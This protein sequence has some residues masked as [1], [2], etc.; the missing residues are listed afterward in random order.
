VTAEIAILNRSAI[1]LASDSAVTIDTPTGPKIYEG[2]NKIFALVKGRP[3]GVMIYDSAEHLGVPWETIIKAYR[4]SRKD[5]YFPTLEEYAADFLAFVTDSTDLIPIS[6]HTAYLEEVAEQRA[7][8]VVERTSEI[9]HEHLKHGK[10]LTKTQ[11]RQFIGKAVEDERNAWLARSDGQWAAA[12]AITQL[13]KKH[14]SLIENVVT[15]VLQNLPA[16]ARQRVDIRTMIFESLRKVPTDTHGW[17]IDPRSGVV[18]AGFGER[19]F[20]PRLIPYDIFGSVDGH[21]RTAPDQP[22]E[23][24]VDNPAVIAPFAQREM[25]DGFM[26]GL[27][28]LVEAGLMGYLKGVTKSF[29]QAT[30]DLLQ[31]NVPGIDPAAVSALSGP[32]ASLVLV[33]VRELQQHLQQ[34]TS[35]QVQP[36]V[37][38]VAFLPKDELA[39]MAE[40]LV[41]LTSLK[42]RVSIDDPQTVGGPVDV[43]VISRGDGFV[44]IKRKH[45]FS[46]ELNPSWAS[47]HSHC[48]A[49]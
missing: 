8:R 27:N 7:R 21:L 40:S 29:P 48:S 4:M 44:W 26:T 25:V 24:T 39:A 17:P 38:S 23:I 22:V 13:A 32:L 5:T 36:I 30:L 31:N 18:I 10:R 37:D 3:V 12:L 14:R 47:T 43:A 42:R 35:L 6:L 20:F 41:N 15:R 28:P 33:M 49:E 2:A 46:Q 34:L 11:I 45:Y 16:T 1:A 9:A 19:E